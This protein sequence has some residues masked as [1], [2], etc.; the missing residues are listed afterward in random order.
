MGMSS[1]APTIALGS[2]SASFL[3]GTAAASAVAAAAAAAKISSNA[4]KVIES[5]A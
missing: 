5:C 3:S 1:V 2:N 4:D